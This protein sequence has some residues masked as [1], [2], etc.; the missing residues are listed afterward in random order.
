[1]GQIELLNKAFSDFAEASRSLENY[2][3][4]LE[5]EVR[6][7]RNEVEKKNRQL[8]TSLAETERS[9]VFLDR[10]LESLPAAVLV[11]DPEGKV[12]H[13][14]SAARTL[15]GREEPLRNVL[16]LPFDLGDTETRM[17]DA[18]GRTVHLLLRHS[19]VGEVGS[20]LT[21][22][23]ITRLRELEREAELNRRLAAMGELVA[24]IAHE[25]RNPLGSIELF[26]SMLAEDLDGTPLREAAEGI[27]TGVRSL[28]NTLNNML[29]Y[30]RTRS[31]RRREID[32]R[33]V[34][35]EFVRRNGGLA[36]RSGV[37]FVWKAEPGPMPVAGDGELI[38]QVLFNLL[39][40]AVQAVEG[41]GRVELRLERAG[42][43]YYR[44]RVMDDGP[45]IRESERE[46]IF[47]PFY[48]TRDRGNGL[49]LSIVRSI[50]REH[51]GSVR[52][53]GAPGGGTVFTLLFPR[54]AAE[55][56]V[57]GGA[58]S[59]GRTGAGTAEAGS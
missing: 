8:E 43:A 36:R 56:G 23:D 35:E 39:Q 38:G 3:R 16:D 42:E 25:I 48:S 10:V 47:E 33:E 11:F 19:G 37:D 12:L 52:V 7:L 41:G 32:L 22:Q 46:R 13:A 57:R 58:E 21:A 53:D 1:M 5:A 24:K 28:V 27:S 40:N 2:Y 45:G 31:I 18:G 30:T 55:A 20:L 34:A 44:V 17:E 29:L 15:F 9:R 26:A 54:A 51:D 50:M 49:G 59:G 6:S 4:G 14:N